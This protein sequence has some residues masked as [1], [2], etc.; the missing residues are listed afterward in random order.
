MDPQE[1]Q[2]GG[3]TLFF[4]W[5]LALLSGGTLAKQLAGWCGTP[6]PRV[7]QERGSHID[8]VAVMTHAN[9]S[10]IAEKILGAE[11]KPKGRAVSM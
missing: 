10:A 2:A 8:S 5:L 6:D 9:A 4:A 1:G 3:G 7:P 11:R